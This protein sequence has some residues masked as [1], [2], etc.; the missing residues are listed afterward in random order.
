MPTRIN[1][2]W[3]IDGLEDKPLVVIDFVLLL[4]LDVFLAKCSA[5]VVLFLVFD[6]LMKFLLVSLVNQILPSF[7]G[8]NDLEIDL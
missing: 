7:D 1:N 4:E 6:I 5:G 2:Q 8:E 3:S